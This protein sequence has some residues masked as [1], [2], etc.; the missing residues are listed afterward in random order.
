MLEQIK[1]AI[2]AELPGAFVHVASPDGR[3]FQA[4]V[5]SEVFANVPLL[6]QHRLVMLALKERFDGEA[7]HAMQLKT[8]SPEKW[9]LVKADYH[10]G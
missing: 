6:K 2:E 3:H 7:V 1:E 5:V 8:F 10:L 9:D 4:I